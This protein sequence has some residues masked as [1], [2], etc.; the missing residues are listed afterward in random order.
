MGYQH[1]IFNFN[2]INNHFTREL[3]G[4]KDSLRLFSDQQIL[5]DLY[6]YLLV[7]KDSNYK[8]REQ[9]LEHMQKFGQKYLNE[10]K[11]DYSKASN[12]FINKYLLTIQKV[13]DELDSKLLL[14]YQN[15]NEQ[16][17]SVAPMVVAGLAVGTCAYFTTKLRITT[18]FKLVPLGLLGLAYVY[19]KHKSNLNF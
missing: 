16:K 8:N 11:I 15:P 2:N 18:T 3:L 19:N 6:R 17:T 5:P 13:T 9:A 4:L 7:H 10:N 1:S 14:A 12:I